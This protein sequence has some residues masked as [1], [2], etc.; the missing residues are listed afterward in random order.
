MIWR[1]VN[2]FRSLRS[3]NLLNMTLLKSWRTSCLLFLP[4]NSVLSVGLVFNF[5]G[6]PLQVVHMGWVIER[7]EGTSSSQTFRSKFLALKGC[8]FY[9]FST[10]PVRTSW[11]SMGRAADKVFWVK[12][13]KVRP[14]VW[15]RPESER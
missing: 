5:K 4:C 7:L 1:F 13:T 6:F 15:K 12:G 10:P 14:G 9:I 11:D 8:S 3:P 2:W